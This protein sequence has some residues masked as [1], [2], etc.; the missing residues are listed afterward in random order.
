MK[1][2]KISAPLGLFSLVFLAACE[3]N[4]GTFFREPVAKANA[5]VSVAPGTTIDGIAD[6]L[7]GLGFGITG[8]TP[9][10]V[11]AAGRGGAFVDCGQITQFRDGNKSTYPGSTAVSVLYRKADTQDFLTRQIAVLSRV[12]V[13]LSGNQATV[14]ERHE[15]TMLWTASDGSGSKRQS[16]AVDAGETVTFEDGTVCATGI[17]LAE[18]LR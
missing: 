16:K 3:P 6:Q 4:T 7:R 14:A 12:N 11:S 15:I 17:R 13:T 18:R 9:N 1:G 2:R 5:T 10:S 8:T